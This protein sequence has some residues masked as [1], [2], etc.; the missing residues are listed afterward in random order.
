MAIPLEDVV[1][2]EAR[3]AYM[4]TAY[5][6]VKYTTSQGV[7]AC[8]FV[9]GTAAKSQKELAEAIIK[10]KQ[11][12]AYKPI[13]ATV[14][15]GKFCIECGQRIPMDAAFCEKCGRRVETLGGGD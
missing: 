4:T 6:M 11:G 10:A 2:A 12:L 14:E 9:F 8:S 1:E 7:K 13:K 5:L 15:E 3:R